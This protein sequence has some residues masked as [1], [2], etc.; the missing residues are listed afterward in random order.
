M[1]KKYATLALA[2]TLLVPVMTGCTDHK[3][4]KDTFQQSLNKQ[5][6][7]K[8]YKFAGSA[9]IKLGAPLGSS[10]NPLTAGLL[11]MLKESK[12]EWNG[13]S[14]AESVQFEADLKIT[15]KGAAAAISL[16]VLIKDNKLYLNLP[17]INK[18]DEY[19]V[20]DM[21]QLSTTS[22]SPLSPDNLKNVSQMSTALST[23]ITGSVDAKWFE[24]AKDPVKLS[25]GTAAKSISLEI[26]K[27]NEQELGGI[28]N[29]KLPEAIDVLKTNGLLSPDQADKLKASKT[30]VIQLRAPSKLTVAIDDQGFIRD[31]QI[32]LSFGLTAP[33]GSVSDNQI[34]LHET[35][36]QI[37]KN[38]AFQKDLPKQTKPFDDI[39]KMLNKNKEKK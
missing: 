21:T 22:K 33:D 9:D 23:L 5:A 25:D 39:L 31:E 7:M 28:L 34:S 16:P 3:Q 10:G 32:D 6:E 26:T 36:D 17:A 1:V 29:A 30:P 24:E 35:F 20:I 4:I 14:S 18:P 19:Y 38:P 13:T 12:I 27:K 8:N 37:N 11:G 15:P 2:V